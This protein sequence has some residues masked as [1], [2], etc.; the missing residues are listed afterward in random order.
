MPEEPS[1]ED[2]LLTGGPF[3]PGNPV[4]PWGPLGPWGQRMASL[5]T[6]GLLLA[7]GPQLPR[8][9]PAFS[10]LGPSSP[11]SPG[12]LLHQPLPLQSTKDVQAGAR[13]GAQGEAPQAARGSGPRSPC[14]G[15]PHAPRPGPGGCPP[16]RPASRHRP[17]LPS[18]LGRPSPSAGSRSP[19]HP[20]GRA[21]VLPRGRALTRS[22]GGP[23]GPSPPELPWGR[24]R[25]STAADGVATITISD[26]RQRQSFCSRCHLCPAGTLLN[27]S[28][29]SD[30]G[31]RRPKVTCPLY[32]H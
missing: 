7:V 4:G 21:A 27:T 26:E 10:A 19:A 11:L 8:S 13:A 22:P 9:L 14:P 12:P 1:Q 28:R 18:R 31:P 3:G 30:T 29:A 17:P 2:V 32:T 15:H 6:D 20:A 25:P 24:E 16:R 5:R 23:A